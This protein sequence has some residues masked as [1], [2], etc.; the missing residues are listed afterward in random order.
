MSMRKFMKFF[1]HH[2]YHRFAWTYD[3][4]AAI[5]SVGRWRDWG[6]AALPHVRGPRVLEIGFGPGHL[7]VELKRMGLPVIGLDE[8]WQMI[9]HA[10]ANLQRK[11]LPAALLRG[12][13]QNLPFA[14][15][16]LDSVL[17][18]FPSEYI[19]D[20]RTQAE[21]LRILKPGGRLVLLPMASISSPTP[22][23]RVA[24]WLFHVTGQAA[25][26]SKSREAFYGNIFIQ[27]GFRVQVIRT[28]LRN[29]AVMILLA[30][31]PLSASDE[32]MKD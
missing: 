8:S 9:R 13:A 14:N 18:T 17:C 25:D 11:K 24:K 1:Y 16:S 12:Y 6:R 32:L 31:K 26:L 21:L 4:V 27:A 28:E 5:V 15:S 2:F 19:A 30:E 20:K 3:F 22:P 29:S 23:D 10:R 7:L